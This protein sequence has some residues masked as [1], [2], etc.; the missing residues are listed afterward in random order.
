MNVQI[1]KVWGSSKNLFGVIGGIPG[2]LWTPTKFVI[3]RS[4]H[5]PVELLLNEPDVSERRER[6]RL[7]RESKISELTTAAYTVSR[8][9]PPHL[10]FPIKVIDNSAVGAHEQRGSWGFLL[11]RYS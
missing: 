9:I 8:A 10:R 6:T 3:W 11:D 7:W 1:R 5:D 4:T 2:Y